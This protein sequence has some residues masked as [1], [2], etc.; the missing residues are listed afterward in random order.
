[1]H[2]GSDL[3]IVL[4]YYSIPIALFV[5]AKKRHDL[6]HKW[7]FMLFA[8]FI[9]LCGTTHLMAIWTTWQPNYAL[10]G[11]IKLTTAIVSGVTAIL[12]WPAIP[13]LLRLPSPATLAAANTALHHQIL[14]RDRLEAELKQINQELEGRVAQRT[15]ELTDLNRQLKDEIAQRVKAEDLQKLLM[16]ELAH[17][18]KNTLATVKAIT[19]HTK[20]TAHS[21]E[22]FYQSLQGRLGAL[23]HAHTLLTNS[24]WTGTNIHALI[25]AIL[26][27]YASG[28]NIEL[29]GS[30]LT[31][32]PR[33][34]LTL[35]LVFH[36]LATNA[37]KYGA[38]SVQSGKLFVNWK[39]STKQNAEY[40]DLEWIE[41][42][43]PSQNSLDRKGFGTTLLE[44]A[45]EHELSGQTTVSLDPSG[46]RF[47]MSCPLTPSAIDRQ[48]NGRDK[49]SALNTAAKNILLVEDE[50]IIALDLK[51][52]LEEAGYNVIGPVSKVHDAL[53][54]IESQ[55]IDAAFLDV[56]LG[57]E[58]GF[59][60]AQLLKERSLPFVFTTGYGS[61]DIPSEFSG[62]P[63]AI[64][65]VNDRQVTDILQ[66]F[67]SKSE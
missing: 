9:L 27:P 22:D 18:V 24:K 11:L 50:I 23:A 2:V 58:K 38:L 31:L 6:T 12:L 53:E 66:E 17:R 44:S 62:V 51:R 45:I 5:F 26:A 41:K 39:A 47:E 46:L 54:I 32:S 8:A 7:M 65:P 25:Q 63:H 16:S 48:L 40:L 36:E 57:E 29:T 55:K 56:N 30:D 4:A 1:L 3:L 35:S 15:K 13:K 19:G 37:S 42:G 14:E 33:K 59:P 43:G 20:A 60:I 64:K 21:P 10:E 34:S 52:I 61:D 49:V 67:F 28:E